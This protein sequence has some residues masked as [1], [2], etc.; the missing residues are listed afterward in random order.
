MIYVQQPL[1][2]KEPHTAP[3]KGTPHAQPRIPL[4]G[5]L[6]VFTR[7]F[8]QDKCTALGWK[9]SVDNGIGLLSSVCTAESFRPVV[10]EMRRSRISMDT[11]EISRAT[12]LK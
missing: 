9:E 6:F 8:G 7:A 1:Q 5:A 4:T 12:S 2:Q 10:S 11:D 3:T